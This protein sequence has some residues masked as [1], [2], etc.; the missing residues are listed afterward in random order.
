MY[1][2]KK[3]SKNISL[4]EY[5]AIINAINNYLNGQNKSDLYVFML[6]NHLQSLLNGSN[7]SKAEK[8]AIVK[9]IYN[10]I[11]YCKNTEH[12]KPLIAVALLTLILKEYPA[13]K[14]EFTQGEYEPYLPV[15]IQRLRRIYVKF[16]I[17]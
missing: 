6:I 1:S 14:K 15:E 8:D 11:D 16:L 3:S 4:R 7:L 13:A 10:D 17:E 5:N 2:N 9:N 12:A